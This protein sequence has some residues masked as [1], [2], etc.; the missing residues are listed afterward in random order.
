MY[1]MKKKSKWQNNA[2]PMHNISFTEQNSYEKILFILYD[3]Q[4]SLFL[5]AFR[6]KYKYFK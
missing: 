4:L 1:N 2:G 5:S 3:I 6:I